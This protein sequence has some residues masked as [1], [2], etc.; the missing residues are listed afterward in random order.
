MFEW[1]NK[2]DKDIV[3]EVM[4]HHERLKSIR[5]PLEPLMDLCTKLF[6]PRTWD[7]QK[8]VKPGKEPYGVSI[9]NPVPS[10]ARRKF[11]AGFVSMTA[12]KRDQAEQSWINFI[13]HKRKM[14]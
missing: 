4:Q 3:K 6:M 7:M 8:S 12:T 11:A 9:Y 1:R 5:K 2:E 14:M 10:E 13:A